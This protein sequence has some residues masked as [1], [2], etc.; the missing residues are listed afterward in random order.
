M[1]KYYV[2]QKASSCLESR[3]N[4]DDQVHLQGSINTLSIKGRGFKVKLLNWYIS[5]KLALGK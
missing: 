3:L 4:S 2:E 1:I 5:V